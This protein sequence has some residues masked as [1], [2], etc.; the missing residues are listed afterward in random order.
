MLWSQ[1]LETGIPAIDNQHKE[2]FRQIDILFDKNNKD[3]VPQTLKF[4][5][6]YVEKHFRDEQLLHTQARYPKAESHKKM[7]SDFVTAFKKMKQEYDAGNGSLMILLKIN[8]AV[9]DWLKNHIMIH[10]KEFAAYYKSVKK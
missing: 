8:R 2:L 7:H 4:L 1:S 10:D 5:G 9:A 6:E 3:R